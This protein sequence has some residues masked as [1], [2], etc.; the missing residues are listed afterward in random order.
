MD[1]I[2]GFIITF[3]IVMLFLG[4]WTGCWTLSNDPSTYLSYNGVGSYYPYD[5]GKKKK[6]VANKNA[7]KKKKK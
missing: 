3:I 5:A 2:W 4:W 6:V 1:G 7:K